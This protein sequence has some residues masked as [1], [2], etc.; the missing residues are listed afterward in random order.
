MEIFGTTR[1]GK[2]VSLDCHLAP[3]VSNGQPHLLLM[4]LDISERKRAEEALKMHSLILQN[5]AEGTL[6][7]S[8]DQTILFANSALEAMFG[9]EPGELIGKQVSVLNAWSPEETARFNQAVI[10]ATE[11]GKVWHGQYENRRKDGTPFTSES[12]VIRLDLGGHDHFISVQQDITERQRAE[13]LLQAQRDV[14][15]SLSLTSD[16]TMALKRFLEIAVQIGG[17]D[18]GGVY[19]LNPVTARAGSGRAPRSLRLIRPG[20]RSFPTDSPEMKLVLQGQS[21]FNTYQN[22][23]VHHSASLLREGL[24]AIAVIPL[25]TI[26]ESSAR[27]TWPRTPQRKSLCRLGSSSRRSP[28]RPPEPLPASAPRPSA[29]AWN[30]SYWKSATGSRPASARTFTT[31][32][33]S[34]W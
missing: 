1:F 23:P 19:L 5:M 26:G 18:C 27:S 24:R 25:A 9:Y 15:V 2:A 21:I 7:T 4:A 31:A 32:S 10:Q 33:A 20:S 13:S 34:I 16:M 3:F 29:T 12:R 11:G 28:P 22:L 17:L 8:P 30:A 6:L 14:G